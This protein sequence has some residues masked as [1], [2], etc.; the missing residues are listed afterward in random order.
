MRSWPPQSLLVLKNFREVS[1]STMPHWVFLRPYASDATLKRDVEDAFDP[2]HV[3]E[4]RAGVL[5][6]YEHAIEHPKS[7]KSRRIRV[8][9]SFYKFTLN[10]PQCLDN[11]RKRL[12]R[13]G[14]TDLHRFVQAAK[15]MCSP[16]ANFEHS[17][18]ES[19][20]IQLREAQEEWKRRNPDRPLSDSI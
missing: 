16:G 9:S 11:L 12:R 8:R 20:V 10:D 19:F 3:T 1:S 5:V 17:P 2:S 4:C 6:S 13:M 15:Y 18:R 14:D 7:S